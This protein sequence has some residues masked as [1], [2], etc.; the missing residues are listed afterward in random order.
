M[1]IFSDYI[2]V[3]NILLLV[4]FLKKNNLEKEKCFYNK[5]NKYLDKQTNTKMELF[6]ES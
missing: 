2:F 1:V 3:V 5:S 6:F 4:N